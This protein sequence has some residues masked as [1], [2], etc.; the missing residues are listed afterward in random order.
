M[1]V[2]YPFKSNLYSTGYR[3]YELLIPNQTFHIIR[4]T[5]IYVYCL[6]FLM[7]HSI[8]T[9]EKVVKLF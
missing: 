1:S 4:P 9:S 7:T 5:Q 3:M 6:F 2:K 8:I